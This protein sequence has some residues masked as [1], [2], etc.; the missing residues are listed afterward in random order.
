MEY[1]QRH[2]G[3]I[4]IILILLLLPYLYISQYSNPVADD[5]IYSYNGKKFELL[6]LLIRDYLGWNGRYTSNILVFSNPMVHNA[7]LVYK[8]FPV[9]I[10]LLIVISYWFC[11][12]VFFEKQ[13]SRMEALI[14]A[15]FLS[16]L[17]LYQMPV[18]SEGIYWYTGS[19]TYQLA[20]ILV[21]I[22]ISMLK[23]YTDATYVLKNKGF[24]ILLLTMLLILCVGFNE[25]LMIALI[26][27]AGG[28]LLIVWKNKLQHQPLFLF[29]LA[30]TLICA[31]I[32]YFAPGNENRAGMAVGNHRF[33]PSLVFSLAQTIRFFMEWISSIPLLVLSAGYYYLNKKLSAN[34]PLFSRSFYLS[35][36]VSLSLLVVVIFIAVFPPYWATGI[37]G[38]HRTLNVA[39]YLFLICWFINLTVCFNSYLKRID[40]INPLPPKLITVMLT[41]AL[42]S[43]FF[44]KNGYDLLTDIFYKKA[45]RYEQQM[46]ERVELMN[47]A[48][49]TIYFSPMMDPPRTLF[50][51]DITE[52]PSHW[53]NKSYTLYFECEH[54]ALVKK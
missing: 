26:A 7:L 44:T 41:V 52:D 18:L 13:C 37:L 42:T 47:S 12:H 39:Y 46:Q 23:L 15:L 32:M 19:V 25:I 48:N 31:A 14:L 50:L 36:V 35:P 49:D 6:D 34:V 29:L 22:Y 3:F 45:N 20:N 28:S 9:I 1:Q 27:F 21:I 33:F 51:Y 17:F 30:I 16:L 5:L 54:K 8:A 43:V 2:Q 11:I 40:T 38:Q 24:H 10:I 53:L 4:L